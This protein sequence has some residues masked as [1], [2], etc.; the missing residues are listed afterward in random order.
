[1]LYRYQ[2]EYIYGGLYT[3]SDHEVIFMN[4]TGHGWGVVQWNFRDDVCWELDFRMLGDL[5]DIS[6]MCFTDT[7]IFCII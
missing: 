4:V 5:S 6:I 3:I 1:M 2:A 7:K